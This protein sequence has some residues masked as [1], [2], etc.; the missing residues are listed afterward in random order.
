VR[1]GE[2]V[3]EAHA[4]SVR[5]TGGE[6]VAMRTLVWCVGVRP[7]PLVDALGLATE[8]GRPVVDPYLAVPD[9]QEILAC[10]DAAAVRDLTRPGKVTTMTAQHATRQG[11]LAA[12]T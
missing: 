8:R 4:D 7:D 3:A 12:R 6:D 1:T 9:Q 2:S 5:R 11:A 10:R